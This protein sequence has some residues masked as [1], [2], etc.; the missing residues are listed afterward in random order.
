MG[1]SLGTSEGNVVGVILGKGLRY[2]L[3]ATDGF[4]DGY[5]RSCF[6]K[7]YPFVHI[8]VSSEETRKR[9]LHIIYSPIKRDNKRPTNFLS[10]KKRLL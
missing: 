1:F 10:P 2:T 5:L 9:H 6:T 7:G 4:L 3:V 8:N